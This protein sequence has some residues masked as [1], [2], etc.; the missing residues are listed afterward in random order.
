MAQLEDRC[1]NLDT[2]LRTSTTEAAHKPVPTVTRPS[3][4]YCFEYLSNF[5]C[6]ENFRH[7]KSKIFGKKKNIREETRTNTLSDELSQIGELV[8]RSQYTESSF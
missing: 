5:S 1:S 8:E 7:I 3:W 4:R 2:A 6:F